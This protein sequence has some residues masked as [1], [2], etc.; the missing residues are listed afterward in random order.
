MNSTSK[1][2]EMVG[3]PMPTTP[4]IKPASTKTATTSNNASG[5]NCD[6]IGEPFF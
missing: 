3:K 5:K 1:A 2:M 4:L 6:I